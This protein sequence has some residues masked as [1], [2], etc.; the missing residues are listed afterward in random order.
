MHYLPGYAPEINPDEYVWSH[1]KA[2]G[3]RKTP[4]KQGESLKEQVITI[5]E[6]IKANFQLVR[7]F[8]GAPHVKYA[9]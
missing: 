1:L 8:F 3:P 4:L 5:L 2:Q 9:Q 6:A 7:S